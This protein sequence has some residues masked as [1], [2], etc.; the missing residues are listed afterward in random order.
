MNS[1]RWS[2]QP[3]ADVPIADIADGAPCSEVSRVAHGRLVAT[4]TNL[5]TN[6]NDADLIRRPQGGPITMCPPDGTAGVP[7]EDEPIT[8]CTLDGAAGVLLEGE[9]TTMC[10]P[11][12]AAGV[13]TTQIGGDTEVGCPDYLPTSGER[14]PVAGCV[15]YEQIKYDMSDFLGSCVRLCK[16]LTNSHD[17]PL[18]PAYA[19]F[20]E[21]TGDDNGLGGGVCDEPPDDKHGTDAWMDIADA[22]GA[23]S[24]RLC[25]RRAKRI[26]QLWI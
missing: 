12:G 13:H 9:Q 8:M 22:T 7:L 3:L 4:A 14:D 21:E 18:R 5:Q 17:E 1:D 15:C 6:E 23:R 11:D 24:Q 16:D 26:S 25:W 20:L 2:L 10:P 19:P